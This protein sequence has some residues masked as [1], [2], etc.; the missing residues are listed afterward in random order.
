M[1]MLNGAEGLSSIVAL[2]ISQ[3]TTDMRTV[4]LTLALAAAT[5]AQNPLTADAKMQWNQGK[6]NILKAPEVRSFGEL[7]G[8]VADASKS[9]CSA[10]AGD[11]KPGT[12]EK[13]LHTKAELVAALKESFDF[14]DGVY[15]GMD[16]KKAMETIKFFGGDRTKAGV[17]FFNS[18]HNYEHYGNIVTYMRLKGIVPPTSEKK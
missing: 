16:D 5:F 6:T 18:M 2:T 1:P 15:N 13:T 8:H 12:A 10:V 17:L 14:C 7:I 11:R 4:L 9:F 3:Y